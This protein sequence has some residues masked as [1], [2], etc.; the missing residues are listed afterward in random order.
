MALVSHLMTIKLEMSSGRHLKINGMW[1][2]P[3]EP[4]DDNQVGNVFRKTFNNK[5]HVEWPW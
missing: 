5:W 3:G 2:G 4:F 1:N